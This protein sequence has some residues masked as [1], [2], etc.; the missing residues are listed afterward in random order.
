VDTVPLALYCAQFIAEQSLSVAITQAIEVG[1]DTDTMA[2]ITG[3]I[4]KSLVT[5][6]AGDEVIR[7]AEQCADFLG[8]Q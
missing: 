4:E 8:E 1:G 6:I 3:Q 2:S 7:I 5:I